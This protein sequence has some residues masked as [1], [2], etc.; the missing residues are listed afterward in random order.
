MSKGIR[1]IDC[2]E[3]TSSIKESDKIIVK[4]SAKWCKPCVSIAEK[5]KK[6]YTYLEVD[7]INLDYDD[8]DEVVSE[9]NITKLPTFIKYN[10]GVETERLV[11]TNMDN[12][13][14]FCSQ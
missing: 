1:P 13:R 9:L 12:I 2:D 11:S 10:N 7:F 4:V 3:F 14:S 6:M 8:D 5:V